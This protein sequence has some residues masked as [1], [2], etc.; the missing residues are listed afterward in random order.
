MDDFSLLIDLHQHQPRQGPGEDL[1]TKRAIALAGLVDRKGL[2][3]ADIGCGTGAATLCLAQELEA[4]ITAVDLF[5][6]F[7]EALEDR[8]RALRVDSRIK[9]C[10]ASMDALT[11]A[12]GSLDV[13][14]AEGAIYNM[15]FANG[16][17]AWRPFLKP[18]GLIAVSEITWL[19]A[20]RPDELTRH[21]ESAYPEIN[22]ASAKFRTLEAEGFSPL[23]YFVL[24]K[25]SWL[26]HYY[27]PLQAS[28]KDFAKRHEQS[29]EA[30]ELIAAEEAE[31]ALYEKHSDYYSYGFYIARR[32]ETG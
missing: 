26:E 1:E 27:R 13:I 23:G 12:P 19:S 15:G 22:V 29:Q 25:T 24:P 2:Q 14:W 21:W 10:A 9:T 32:S 30:M 17:R 28:F 16:L 7:L 11:F 20:S 4:S 3:I 8:A 6:E 5:P 18:N 31:I